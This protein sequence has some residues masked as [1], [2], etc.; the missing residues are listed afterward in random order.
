MLALCAVGGGFKSQG[1]VILITLKVVNT[2][3]L[4]STPCQVG[5]PCRTF[6]KYNQNKNQVLENNAAK[7]TMK[8]KK[9]M[10]C[11]LHLLTGCVRLLR[12]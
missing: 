9:I 12:N 4:P 5:H 11:F 10:L 7:L 8:Q 3:S 1:R 2:A 6:Q